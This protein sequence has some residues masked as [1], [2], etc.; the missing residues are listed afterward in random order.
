MFS[1][2]AFSGLTKRIYIFLLAL[3]EGTKD[4]YIINK[5]SQYVNLKFVIKRLDFLF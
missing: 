2:L 4:T 5:V 1:D 3:L